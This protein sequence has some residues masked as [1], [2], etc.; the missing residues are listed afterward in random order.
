MSLE[1]I[2]A[3]HNELLAQ[4]NALLQQLLD[5]GL[6]LAGSGAISQSPTSETPA[7]S[8]APK[9]TG[10]KGKPAATA[11]AADDT[12]A[13]EPA[14][15]KKPG[16]K[17]TQNTE[18]ASTPAAESQETETPASTATSG[19]ASESRSD[20]APTKKD[21]IKAMKAVDEA[22][23]KAKLGEILAEFDATNLTGVSPDDYA[24]FIDKLQ[25]AL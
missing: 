25:A 5:N 6:P 8:P 15:A 10:K 19:S 11:Q 12:P 16:S 9:A 4:N 2:M 21:V 24:A 18:T 17:A 7:D 23:G 13:S 20:E 22:H 1:Q 3:Q 14:S